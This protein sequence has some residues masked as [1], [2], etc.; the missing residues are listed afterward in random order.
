MVVRLYSVFDRVANSFS[1]ISEAVN[2]GVAW[3]M[4]R[5]V[6]KDNPNAADFQV[7][8]VGSFDNVKGI[9]IPADVP[10]VVERGPVETQLTLLDEKGGK[11][12][13]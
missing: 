1:P 5:S 8:Y 13:A 11:V 9:L 7:L 2:D 12:D 3:R 6:M 10:T 4:Y